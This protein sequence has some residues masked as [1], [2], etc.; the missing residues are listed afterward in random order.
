MNS[1][2]FDTEFEVWQPAG[3]AVRIDYSRA[4][5]EELRV[6]ACDGLNRLA[7]GG[8]EIG[9]ILFGVR[10]PEAVKILAPGARLRICVWSFLHALG[11]RP[12]RACGIAGLA[13][14][15]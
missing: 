7:H 10:G 12:A 11:Q 13:P 3:C 15:R 8:V 9:G 6:A 2:A 5:M 14:N 4:V 1:T